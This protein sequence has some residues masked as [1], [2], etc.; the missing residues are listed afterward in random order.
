MTT[1]DISDHRPCL[2]LS[3]DGITHTLAVRAVEDVIEGKLSITDFSD[4]ESIVRA[5]L[6]EWLE[7]RLQGGKQ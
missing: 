6:R 1:M 5:V 7:G 4:W 3:A 2:K